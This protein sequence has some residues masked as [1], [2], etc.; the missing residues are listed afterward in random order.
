MNNE[1]NFNRAYINEKKSPFF[2]TKKGVSSIKIYQKIQSLLSLPLSDPFSLRSLL[3]QLLIV[4][5]FRCPLIVGLFSCPFSLFF[6]TINCIKPLNHSW[7]KILLLPSTLLLVFSYDYRYCMAPKLCRWGKQHVYDRRYR[8][9][10]A[11]RDKSWY[12]GLP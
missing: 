3:L 2:Y 6:S 4:C 7:T 1:V 10:K 12:A 8:S 5:S 11:H 9:S